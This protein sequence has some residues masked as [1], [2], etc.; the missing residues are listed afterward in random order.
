MGFTIATFNLQNLVSPGRPFYHGEGLSDADFDWKLDWAAD[1]LLAMDADIVALQEVFDADALRALA[2][3]ADAR[4][5]G[6]ARYRGTLW[7]GGEWRPYREDM[8]FARNLNETASHARPGLAIL[9]RHPIL[10]SGHLQDIAE[11]PISVDF[12]QLGSGLAGE[13]TLTRL[14]R[15]I[16]WARIDA[17][18]REIVLFNVHLKSPTP[19]FPHGGPAAPEEDL[20][21]YDAVGRARGAIRA[22]VR[23]MG[24]ALA[25]RR[26]VVT[27]LDEGLPVIVAG[28]VNAP[29]MGDAALILSGERP[30]PD[31][32]A[33]PR[34]G[35]EGTWSAEEAS[36][37]RARIEGL[38]LDSAEA[39][40]SAR[41][42]RA[43]FH[44]AAFGGVYESLDRL[45]LSVHFRDG[46]AR[47]IGRMRHLRAFNDHLNDGGLPRGRYDLLASDHGQLVARI[48]WL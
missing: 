35:G 37:I 20:M 46:D 36:A 19:E 15:P 9:S 42:G 27:V 44:T 40:A 17:G 43:A 2:A 26:E 41:V 33:E 1:Q 6:T 21:A 8:R 7:R 22:S 24:E 5:A 12:M 3:R 39:V 48:D 16:Q 28:D 47:Q 45:L 23:R 11:R 31:Y 30:E 14:S 32:T 18:G 4:G 38:R 10:D 34:V 25:V 13:W 29:H